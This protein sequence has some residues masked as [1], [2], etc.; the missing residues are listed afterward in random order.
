MA[1]PTCRMAQLFEGPN[2]K[3]GGPNGKSGA[4]TQLTIAT[5]TTHNRNYGSPTRVIPR[6][7][8][9]A[10][11][12]TAVP[13][14]AD[15]PVCIATADPL[16]RSTHTAPES[17]KSLNSYNRWNPAGRWISTWSPCTRITSPSV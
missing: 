2:N 13:L 1:G 16:D 3:V 8:S 4:L 17:P 5:D 12:L 10:V 11:M 6:A 14:P 15:T 7:A 9:T